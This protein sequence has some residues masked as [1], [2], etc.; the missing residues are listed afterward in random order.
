MFIAKLRQTAA[1]RPRAGWAVCCVVGAALCAVAGCGQRNLA[2]ISLTDVPSSATAITAYYRL[3][4]G[5]WKSI[6]PQR[7]LQQ[8]GLELPKD[9]SATLET[10]VFGYNNRVPCS[11]GSATG[12]TELD[13][14]S[15]RELALSFGAT[16]NRCT[17]TAE[18]A[19]FPR[20]KLAVWANSATDIWIAGV[21]GKIVHWDGSAYTK[22]P[23]PQQLA[24][25]PPDWNAIWS[26][27]IDVWIVGSK[28]AVVRFERGTLSVVP[29]LTPIVGPTDW[30]AIAL[31]NT[32]T[33]GLVLAGSNRIVGLTGPTV[34][35]V[36]QFA[37]NC[38]AVTPAGDLNSVGCG[39]IGSAFFCV[40]VTD[41]GGIAALQQ[42][43]I[44]R[45]IKS[46]TT[47]SLLGV[48]VGVN[49][50]EQAFDVR[51]VGKGGF[52]LRGLAP[53]LSGAD[54]NFLAAGTDYSSFIPQSA[55][56]DLNQV[57]GSG[58][59]ELWI[60]GQGGVLLRWPNTP[61]TVPP[62]APFAQTM[63][64]TASDLSSLSGFGS[65]LFFGGSSTSLGYLGPLFTP[66]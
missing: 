33:G 59:D 12:G 62:S 27:G 25:A 43:P 17:T 3:D 4:G 53:V 20:G 51:I 41:G 9:R 65:N 48:Y 55:R 18:P 14:G 15:I 36:G 32:A 1:S 42:S 64:G 24:A 26:N 21:G 44:C 54:P 45:N 6:V 22:I 37:F 58:L 19:D 8:F 10:Q 11:L 52:A 34:Q 5:E 61:S 50:S 57:G 2:V 49:L 39:M 60:A 63:T 7:G 66:N 30:R 28:S 40:F 13:G 31:A 29:L 47:K 35:G 56:V 16:T 46:P 38:G 23:L